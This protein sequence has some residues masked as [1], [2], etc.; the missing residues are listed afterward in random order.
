ML[1]FVFLQNRRHSVLLKRLDLPPVAIH[2]SPAN[3]RRT[4]R[5]SMIHLNMKDTVRSNI[6]NN[7]IS[8][9][10]EEENSLKIPGSKLPS[11]KAAP[12]KKEASKP[13]VAKKDISKTKL[14]EKKNGMIMTVQKLNSSPVK[15]T[16]TP[17][18]KSLQTSEVASSTLHK[19]RTKRRIEMEAISEVCYSSVYFQ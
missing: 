19:S 7:K 18:H 10:I 11:I 5:Q 3:S 13:V 16:D 2:H 12:A 4:R 8:Q 9:P 14:P 1:N 15:S 6:C 17:Q